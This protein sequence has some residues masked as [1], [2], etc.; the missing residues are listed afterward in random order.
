MGVGRGAERPA[1]P[2]ADRS[3]RLFEGRR[4]L[5]VSML[6]QARGI[7]CPTPE[8]AFYVYPSCAGADRQD[9]RRAARSSTP[10]RTFV[11][12][13]LE[14][15]GVA[16]VHGSAFGL[17]PNFRISYATSDEAAGRGLPR[18]QRLHG[19]AELS[20]RGNGRVTNDAGRP[21]RLGRGSGRGHVAPLRTIAE[22]VSDRFAFR[23][24]PLQART[25]ERE[26]QP[27]ASPCRGRPPY[28]GEGAGNRRATLLRR[29]GA[30][31]WPISASAGR[32]S[33]VRAS[34]GGG[35]MRE[36]DISW[37]LA[38]MHL[39]RCWLRGGSASRGSPSAAGTWL[40]PSNM[41][42]FP[43]LL[44]RYSRLSTARRTR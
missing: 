26:L 31:S 14:A 19:L 2:S 18:I 32:R 11:T 27:S 24:G 41:E 15:E 9:R 25:Q 30:S 13:L 17:G 35:V 43:V 34:A 44:P 8:G 29:H 36:C 1:G 3:G 6:N 5:V 33:F 4:D 10:T 12:E 37:S 16:V 20:S 23:R 28:S 42:T 40:P 39:A 7:T 21:A 22:A 38:I